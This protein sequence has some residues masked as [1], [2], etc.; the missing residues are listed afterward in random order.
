MACEHEVPSGVQPLIQPPHDCRRCDQNQSATTTV[1]ED[2][3]AFACNH[4]PILGVATVAAKSARHY[5]AC[6]TDAQRRLGPCARRPARNRPDSV[7]RARVTPTAIAL[8]AP[9][10]RCMVSVLDQEASAAHHAGLEVPELV[11]DIRH[12]DV[13]VVVGVDG[14]AADLEGNVR[15]RRLELDLR[16]L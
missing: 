6:A 12:V 11:T 5:T 8:T 7:D 16:H 4:R 2:R 3:L 10:P 15:L 1:L 14:V 9:A 13:L